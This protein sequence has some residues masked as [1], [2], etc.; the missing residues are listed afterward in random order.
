M[1]LVSHSLICPQCL[2]R[3]LA[4][5]RNQY[6][7]TE[8][9]STKRKKCVPIFVMVET[10]KVTVQSSDPFVGGGHDCDSG[11]Q[12]RELSV[13]AMDGHIFILGSQN[14]DGAIDILEIERG[15]YS[16]LV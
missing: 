13:S 3:G 2:E 7:L 4:H 14:C 11:R 6:R 1:G 9:M 16:R 15:T 12:K 8:G 10:L 5:S